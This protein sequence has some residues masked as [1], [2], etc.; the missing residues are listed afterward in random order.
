MRLMRAW[1][2]TPG[3]KK[4]RKSCPSFPP[5]WCPKSKLSWSE[6]GSTDE[7]ASEDEEDG[8]GNTDEKAVDGSKDEEVD[9]SD[10]EEDGSLDDGDDTDDGDEATANE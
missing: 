9:S 2:K 5:N 6:D 8:S 1:W 7:E 10:V 4:L 3:T